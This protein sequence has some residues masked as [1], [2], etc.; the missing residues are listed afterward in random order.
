M[1]GFKQFLNESVDIGQE[2]EI[3]GMYKD[4]YRYQIR[5]I[6][7]LTGVSVAGIYR[8]LEK[9]GIRPHRRQH[10]DAHGMVIQYHQTG[11]PVQK[12]SELTGFSK[13]Q[14]YNIISKGRELTD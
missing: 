8:V 1:E 3:I 14:C 2:H 13:R 10:D 4:N 6:S 9:Y 5:Q 12:I 11:I 7:E